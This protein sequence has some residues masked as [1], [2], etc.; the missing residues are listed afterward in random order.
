MRIIIL[1]SSKTLSGGTRQAVYLA[2]SL[3]GSGRAVS[4]VCH[5]HSDTHKAAH[6]AGLEC[7]P[8]PPKIWDAGKLL[9]SLMPNGEEVVLHAFHNR[10]VKLAAYLGTLWRL[11]GLPVVCV[12]HRGVTSRPGNPLPYLLPGIRSFLVNSKACAD[13]LPLLWR[14]GRCHVVSNS[15]PDKRLE[16]TTSARE[17]KSRLQIPEHH[18]V[19]GNIA[20][21]NPQ[22]GV[23]RLLAAFCKARGKMPEATL[24]VV[25]VKPELW[26]PQCKSLGIAGNVRLIPKTDHVADYIQTFSMLVFP[27]NFIESQPNVVMEGMSMGVP[28]IASRVG[29]I[30]ELLPAHCLF[31]PLDIEEISSMMINLANDSAKMSRLAEDNLAQKGRFSEQT[32]LDAILGHYYQALAGLRVASPPARSQADDCG[33]I[34]HGSNEERRNRPASCPMTFGES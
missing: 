13:T 19:I 4:F 14:K 15:I 8:L 16:A 23:G 28:V 33:K 3:A 31:N 2:K 17:M 26:L 12:A 24:V 20:N 27:S 7:S 11:Q 29:G 21:D 6:E 34:R 18:L 1:T 25:G 10:G 32:R 9:R 5:A 22:K 30:G